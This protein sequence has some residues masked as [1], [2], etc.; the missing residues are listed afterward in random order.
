MLNDQEVEFLQA[1]DYFL[2]KRNVDEQVNKLLYDV[3]QSLLSN[4]K[5]KTD[6]FI[7]EEASPIPGKISKGY[8]YKGFPYQVFDFPS[9][10][11][12]KG[13]FSFRVIVWYGNFF[14]CNLILTKKFIPFY[15]NKLSELT[16]SEVGVIVDENIWETDTSSLQTLQLNSNHL[17]LAEDYFM[18]NESIRL[19]RQFS[20]NQIKVLHRLS[21][22]CFNEWLSK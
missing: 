15:S 6:W 12:D 2:L 1:K 13:I 5:S 10:F 22:E 21:I 11:D 16:N 3:Q 18:K 8:N 14:S 4:W 7:P 17:K 20:M 9:V 19:F